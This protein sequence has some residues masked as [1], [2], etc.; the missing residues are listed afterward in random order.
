MQETPVQSLGQE[1][2]LEKG[3]AIHSSILAWRIAWTEEPCGLQSMRSQ[4]AG[5]NWV[6]NTVS[7][8]LGPSRCLFCSYHFSAWLSLDGI[9]V[10][11]SSSA[12][13]QRVIHHLFHRWTSQSLKSRLYYQRSHKVILTDL[14]FRS[15]GFPD[16][17]F[18]FLHNE[19]SLQVFEL[20]T[21]GTRE[22]PFNFITTG[23][24]I[25]WVDWASNNKG[26]MCVSHSITSNSLWP[27]GL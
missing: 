20:V 18:F 24:K 13:E 6:T 21:L 1:Y 8:T 17:E 10:L 15:I 25:S 19:E 5:H 9:Y 16:S 2:P 27:H 26:C 12:V 22:R 4:R 14:E 23:K 11:T 3:M 7:A